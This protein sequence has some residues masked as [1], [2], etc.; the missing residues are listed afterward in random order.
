[1]TEQQADKIIKLLERIDSKLESV[2]N[3]TGG[4]EECLIDIRESIKALQ[5]KEA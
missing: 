1:M 2:I 5:D 3:A 4:S